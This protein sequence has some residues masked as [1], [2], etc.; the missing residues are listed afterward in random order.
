M[1]SD[2]IW[3]GVMH[4]KTQW[5]GKL[6]TALDAHSEKI[7]RYRDEYREKRTPKDDWLVVTVDYH[8]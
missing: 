1:I 6:K 4:V 8:S 3:N 7:K 5:D 2:D